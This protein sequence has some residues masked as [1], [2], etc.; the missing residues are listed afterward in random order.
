MILNLIMNL[1]VP[2]CRKKTDV[3]LSQASR[4][5]KKGSCI[6]NQRLSVY[7]QQVLVKKVLSL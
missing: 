2:V 6:T 3:L 1:N 4:N 7:L 5:A